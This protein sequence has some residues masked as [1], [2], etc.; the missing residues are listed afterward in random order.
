M[1]FWIRE[2]LTRGVALQGEPLLGDD[3]D[4]RI[5]GQDRRVRCLSQAWALIIRPELVKL[6]SRFAQV[7]KGGPV[8]RCTAGRGQRRDAGA[9][10]LLLQP[11]QLRRADR[12]ACAARKRRR[13]AGAARPG[14]ARH[15]PAGGRRPDGQKG[16]VEAPHR[17]CRRRPLRHA[18]PCPLRQA[19]AQVAVQGDQGSG[20]RLDAGRDGAFPAGQVASAAAGGAAVQDARA[21]RGRGD[22]HRGQREV[23]AICAQLCAP[24]LHSP[25]ARPSLS[26]A[27][28]GRQAPG[29]SAPISRRRTRR[30]TTSRSSPRWPKAPR[31]STSIRSSRRSAARASRSRTTLL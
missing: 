1:R 14:R 21:A 20:G 23:H 29:T 4:S 17:R 7:Y 28:A 16:A 27:R 5:V 9:L 2:T 18:R 30:A 10:A 8:A 26:D 19:F 24:S 22:F 31:F 25:L 13:R 12:T 11:H 15:E 6:I 3:T